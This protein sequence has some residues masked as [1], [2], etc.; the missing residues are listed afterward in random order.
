MSQLSAPVKFETVTSSSPISL[1]VSDLSRMRCDLLADDLTQRQPRFQVVACATSVRELIESADLH[2]AVAIISSDLEE[3]HLTGF[4]ALRELRASHPAIRGIMLLDRY[5]R[6][7]VIAAF[8]GG[9][10]GVFSRANS[11]EEFATCIEQVARGQVGA[12][13]AELLF[14]IEALSTAAP[15]RILPAP[16]L[17][18]TRREQQLALM[19]VSGLAEGD[20]CRKLKINEHNLSLCLTR[21]YEKLGIGS[22]VELVLCLASKRAAAPAERRPAAA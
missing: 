8:R 6:D 21:V 12:G 20:I 1:V 16:T 19:V 7:L 18:L 17:S 15:L 9:A 10:R 2:P 14:L 13:S 22:R 4:G 11:I 3:G 5:E